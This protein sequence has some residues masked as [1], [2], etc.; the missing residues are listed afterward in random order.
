MLKKILPIYFWKQSHVIENTRIFG[1]KSAGSG[2]GWI[3]TNNLTREQFHENK[4][5]RMRVHLAV[6]VVSQS[7]IRLI[8]KHASKCGGIVKNMNHLKIITS[9]NRLVDICNN[10]VMIIKNN[11]KYVRW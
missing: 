1:K 6:Q 7:M 8:D 4:Y 9:I 11:L 5:S 2:T 10:K 3:R